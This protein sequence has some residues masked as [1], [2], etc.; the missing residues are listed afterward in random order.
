MPARPRR[1]GLTLVTRRS[2]KVVSLAWGLEVDENR[3][4]MESVKGISEQLGPHSLSSITNLRQF[5]LL[6]Q[7]FQ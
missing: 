5:H 6:N 1:M 4:I 7:F 2:D 3:V